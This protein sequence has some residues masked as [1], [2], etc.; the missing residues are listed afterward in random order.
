VVS[1]FLDNPK[2]VHIYLVIR[3]LN[4]VNNTIDL[5]L[6]FSPTG[7]LTLV[8]YA[9]ASYAHDFE[10]K[11]RTGYIFTFGGSLITWYSG[12][13][14]VVAQSAAK[15]EY[16]AAVSASND[17]IWLKQL[18]K[19]L[20]YSQDTVT[21]YDDNKRRIINTLKLWLSVFRVGAF[22]VFP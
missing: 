12:L 22:K 3:I 7:S 18:S 19:D 8:G 4:Y 15:A 14:S 13:Q 21:I 9:D 11:S 20:G 1:R 2:P 10:Y 17:A 16:Y 6:S 5:N